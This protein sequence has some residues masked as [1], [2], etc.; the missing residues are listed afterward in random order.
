MQLSQTRFCVTLQKLAQM[1]VFVS[2][3]TKLRVNFRKEQFASPT[4]KFRIL[5]SR[6]DWEALHYT[7]ERNSMIILV[8]MQNFIQSINLI[9]GASRM[10]AGRGIWVLR[11]GIS[12][13]F[14]HSFIRNFRGKRPFQ[15]HFSF[16][17]QGMYPP[18]PQDARLR[19]LSI[20]DSP[21]YPTLHMSNWPFLFQKKNNKQL[22]SSS[23]Y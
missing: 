2:C 23:W 22:K 4:W 6:L 17:G 8:H 21:W 9:R 20:L 19:M 10:K 1:Y 16:R 7:V 18:S 15:R 14:R 5:S 13:R 3:Q 12:S 11:Q